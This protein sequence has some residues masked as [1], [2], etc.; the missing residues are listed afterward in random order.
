MTL[1]TIHPGNIFFGY[2]VTT[3]HQ[4][5]MGEYQALCRSAG[6]S[7]VRSNQLH[8]QKPM[9]PAYAGAVYIPC[10]RSDDRSLAK[11]LGKAT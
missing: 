8:T 1:I 4:C 6:P 3:L 11:L 10:S 2:A 7:R 5:A 9:C